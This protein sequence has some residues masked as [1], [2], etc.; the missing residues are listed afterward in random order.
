MWTI[1]K[2]IEWTAGYF[3]KYGVP[4]PRLDAEL[5]LSHTLNKKRI[6][7]YLSFEQ[8]VVEGDLAIFKG[9][10][11]RRAKRE[12]LQY[13]IGSQDFCGVTMQVTPAVLIPRPETELLV[14][15]TLSLVARR[16]SLGKRA[17]NHESRVTILDLCTGSGCIIAALAN[18]LPDAHFTGVDISETAL[19]IARQ[20]T[21]KWKDRVELLH[22]NLFEALSPPPIPPRRWNGFHLRGGMG[23]G[24]FDVIISN[25]PYVA[26]SD[27]PTL[28]PEIR[29]HEPKEALIAGE[30][31]LAIIKD[32]T[33][34]AHRFLKPGGQ[35]IIELGD[36]QADAVRQ[37]VANAGHYC[38]TELLKDYGGVERIIWT[39]LSSTA[40]AN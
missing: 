13:I 36:G 24:A 5:L 15:E 12:P 6:A 2:L 28:Q 14:E 11:Q 33:N 27:W 9:Y 40:G 10:V 23:G 35:L 8:P 3:A 25:P 29:D 38:K 22:G 20:N 16:S 1:L 4:N 31:G 18:K 32:I 7:L 19:E 17:T 26:E 30:D 37:L 21:E 39:S 34:N